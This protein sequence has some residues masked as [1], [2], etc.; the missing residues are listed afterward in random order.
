MPLRVYLSPL[1]GDG[2]FDN[3]F[4]PKIADTGVPWV[5]VLASNPDGRPKFNWSLVLVNTEDFTALDSDT[6]LDAFPSADLTTPITSLNTA[7]RNR[8]QNGLTPR[9]INL[10]I[11]NY[12]TVGDLIDAVGKIQNPRFSLSSLSVG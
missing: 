8:I 3:K 11:T 2:T 1:V 10:T 12:A 5:C 4:R 6:T 9:G 7:T